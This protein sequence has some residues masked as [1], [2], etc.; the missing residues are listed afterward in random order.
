M[1][2]P[3]SDIL[4]DQLQKRLDNKLCDRHYEKITWS[5]KN[6]IFYAT[7]R[8]LGERLYRKLDDELSKGT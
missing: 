1:M 2:I 6:R 5:V 3:I 7:T 8:K 4:K